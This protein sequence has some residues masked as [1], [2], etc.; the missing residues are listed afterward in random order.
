[1]SPM[2][3]TSPFFQFAN[4]SHSLSLKLP[5]KKPNQALPSSDQSLKSMTTLL[6]NTTK[7]KFDLVFA[8]H[9]IS[10]DKAFYLK[11]KIITTLDK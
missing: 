9:I 7:M 2:S 8:N 10:Q 5:W 11:I 6:P 3:K 1:M 4:I